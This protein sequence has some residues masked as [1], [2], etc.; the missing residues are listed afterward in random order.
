MD[1]VEVGDYFANALFAVAEVK[2]TYF[3]SFGC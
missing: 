1:E 3:Y 2:S